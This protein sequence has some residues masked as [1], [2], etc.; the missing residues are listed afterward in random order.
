MRR[1]SL[2]FPTNIVMPQ[3]NHTATFFVTTARSGTQWVHSVLRALC[4][5]VLEAEH[6]PIGYIYDPRQRL[7][8][9]SRLLALRE[10]PTIQRH[11]ERIHNI[12][13]SKCYVEV[14]FPCFASLP[15]MLHEF[16]DQFQVVQLVRHPVYVAASVV[17]HG[18]Y[19][20]K[21]RPDIEEFIALRPTDSGTLWPQYKQCWASMSHFERGLYYWGQV[22]A[23]GLEFQTIYG[24]VPYHRV[25]FE[26]LLADADAFRRLAT[27]VG[28]GEINPTDWLDSVGTRVDHYHKTTRKKIEIRTLSRHPE[29]VSLAEVLGYGDVLQLDKAEIK[30]RYSPDFTTKALSMLSRKTARGI[31]AISKARRA[32]FRFDSQ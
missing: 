9:D 6:E 10:Q 30:R 20:A 21:L 23:Y 5:D 15:L 4:K 12:L 22:H 19:D 3:T 25:R 17:T 18:W 13:E 26:D 28:G 7:R 1:R 14:G 29:I 11:L 24:Q 2:I 31:H 27:F 32:L 16:K 8:N